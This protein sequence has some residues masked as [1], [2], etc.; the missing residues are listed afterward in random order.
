MKYIR[1]EYKDETYWAVLSDDTAQLL[2]GAPYEGGKPIECIV[3]LDKCRL[4]APCKPG[5]IIAVG[6]NYL[7]HISEL[8]GDAKLPDNPILFIKP[9]STII[10]P[11]Q[12][13]VLPPEEISRRVDHEAELAFVVS[14]RAKNITK[15]EAAN[16]ILGYTCLNDI[17]ARDIQIID[18]QWTRAKSF[19]TF[20]PIGPLLTDEID[21]CNVQLRSSVNGVVKQ[22]ENSNKQIWNVY[23]LLTFISNMMTLEPGD[24]ITTGTPAGISSIRPGDIVTISI[25][26]IGDLTNQVAAR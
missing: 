9:A 6:K 17:T 14:R 7:D 12:A 21:P 10:G 23:E 26:G 19:D 8:A 15:T 3:S 4:L 24:V 1:V 18:G 2:D 13:I 5:K 11:D 20:A 22:N 25:E 16:Y